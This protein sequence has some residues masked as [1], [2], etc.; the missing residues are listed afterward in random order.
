ME[1]GTTLL[2]SLH[3]IL[4]LIHLTIKKYLMYS[5]H[6]FS[7]LSSMDITFNK[8]LTKL[9]NVKKNVGFCLL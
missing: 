7:I 8:L 9:A 4:Y 6:E 5:P 2:H 1:T 3:K